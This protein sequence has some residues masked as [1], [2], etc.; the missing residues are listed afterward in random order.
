MVTLHDKITAERKN[1]NVF[2][3]NILS[4]PVKSQVKPKEMIR[5]DSNKK[6][7]FIQGKNSTEKARKL[8]DEYLKKEIKS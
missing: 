2:H 4:D 6:C 5:I 7:T 1:V 3:T 8:Y